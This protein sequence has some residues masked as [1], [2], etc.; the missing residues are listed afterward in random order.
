MREPAKALTS[1]L[2]AAVK[3]A[4]SDHRLRESLL[5]QTTKK[6]GPGRKRWEDTNRKNKE[7]REATKAAIEKWRNDPP[8]DHSNRDPEYWTA[9]RKD[10]RRLE[11]LAKKKGWMA[12]T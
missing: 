8:L 4:L 7:L 9:D 10:R 5:K 1:L 6:K 11:N 12:R 3:P 2:F